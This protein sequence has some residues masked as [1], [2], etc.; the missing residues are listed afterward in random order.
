MYWREKYATMG[1]I[2]STNHRLMMIN[3]LRNI[4]AGS[5]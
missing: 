1:M 2:M 5:F 3:E 4:K